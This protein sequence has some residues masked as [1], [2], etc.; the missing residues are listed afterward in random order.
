MNTP[1]ASRIS[2]NLVN[3]KS[4]LPSTIN[5]PVSHKNER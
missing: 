4:S 3:E 2:E 1:S 5:S